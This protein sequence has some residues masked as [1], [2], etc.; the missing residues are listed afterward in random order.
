MNFD[1]F[2]SQ[3]RRQPIRPLPAAWKAEILAAARRAGDPPAVR[4]SSLGAVLRD[5][6]WPHPVAWGG[7]A[8]AW[9]LIFG[10]NLAANGDAPLVAWPA[11][12]SFASFGNYWQTQQRLVSELLESPEAEPALPPRRV[13][14]PRGTNSQSSS[15]EYYETAQMA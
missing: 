10:L 2:E 3:L 8:A 11:T 6:L 12:G 13:P 9:V 1:D 15:I 14:A 5:W 7:L 4:R